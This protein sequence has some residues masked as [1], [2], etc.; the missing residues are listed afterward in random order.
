VPSNVE[1]QTSTSTAKMDVLLLQGMACYCMCK[2]QIYV[3]YVV[4]ATYTQTQ[5]YGVLPH[6]VS[7]SNRRGQLR[8][9][10]VHLHTLINKRRA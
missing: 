5:T 2:P 9:S 7:S 8:S 4:L 6:V 1:P 10:M 3:N